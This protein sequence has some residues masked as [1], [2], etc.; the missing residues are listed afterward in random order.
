MKS[1]SPPGG[2]NR[3]FTVCYVMLC[4]VMLCY[5][6]LCY[7]MLCYVV[8]LLCYVMLY[9]A[10]LKIERGHTKDQGGIERTTIIGSEN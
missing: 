4:Y 6:M 5:V 9:Y 1:I 3:E 8:M 10:M 7:V 2:L